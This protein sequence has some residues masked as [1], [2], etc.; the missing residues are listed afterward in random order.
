MTQGIYVCIGNSDDKLSQEDWHLFF[1]HV[2]VLIERHAS[3]VYGVWHSLPA[4]RWQNACFGFAV[5]RS[6]KIEFIKMRLAEIGAQYHQDWISWVA[7]PTEQITTG[8]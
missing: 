6:E 3:Q 2:R 1:N 7:G 8:E 5:E 4:E